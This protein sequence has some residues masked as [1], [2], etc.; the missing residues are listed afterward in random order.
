MRSSAGFPI[1]D[2]DEFWKLILKPSTA[3]TRIGTVPVVLLP[4]ETLLGLLQEIRQ[5][6]GRRADD[7]L[8]RAGLEAG[9]AFV[10]TM[11]RWTGSQ[12]PME[13]I[14]HLGDVYSRFGW[15][16]VE[17]IQVD[18]ASRQARLRLRRTLETHGAEGRFDGPA[19]PF[20]RG[21]LAGLFR[22]LFWTDAVDCVERTCQGKGDKVCE[23][24]LAP[25]E[26]PPSGPVAT[27]PSAV[28]P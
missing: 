14:D 10:G 24:L 6:L 16:A 4:R 23:F 21:Y 15:F 20:L 12:E 25:S 1:K 28:G 17:S 11:T 19:C 13:M 27:R 5:A 3:D 9:Q 7:V 8:Y 18:P 26:A 2:I 22:S